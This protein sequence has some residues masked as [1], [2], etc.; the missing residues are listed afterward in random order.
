MAALLQFAAMA[1]LAALEAIRRPVF[2]LVALVSLGGTVLLPFLLNYTLGDSARIIRDSAL[3]LYLTSGLL[4]AAYA[5][6]E[7]LGRELRRGTAATVLAKPVARPVFFL[8]KA[9]GIIGALALYSV[10]ALAATLLATRAGASDIRLD[11]AAQTPALLALLLAPALAGWWNHRTRRPFTSAAFFLL[12][13]FLLAALAI[14]AGFP[15][16]LD[17]LTF[18]ANFDWPILAVGALLFC[19][20]AMVAAAA[21]TLA[22]RLSVTPVLLLTAGLFVFGLMSDYLLGPRLATSLAARVAYAIL[23]NVQAFW[24]LDALDA[25]TPIP[26]AYFLGAAAYAAAWSAAALA[27]GIALFQRQE[28]T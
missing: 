16:P 11:W 12:L 27:I 7:G 19:C 1:R 2:L 18:P 28:I 17:H 14:A 13:I 4:L 15:T 23:P 3:A 25:A 24:L 20:L 21:L 6:G 26:A 8:A 5:A 22:T 9:A 10:A